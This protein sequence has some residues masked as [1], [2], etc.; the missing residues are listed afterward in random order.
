MMFFKKFVFSALIIAAPSFA[1]ES[2]F[3]AHYQG[4]MR[5]QNGQLP[6]WVQNL[7]GDSRTLC[8]S[9]NDEC[10][11]TCI[12]SFTLLVQ[13]LGAALLGEI[14]AIPVTPGVALPGPS[15]Q[16]TLASA[17]FSN[18]FQPRNLELLQA[19]IDAARFYAEGVRDDLGPIEL[20]AR[21]TSWVDAQRALVT[22]LTSG[23]SCFPFLVF[24]TSALF[25]TLTR[26]LQIFI[27]LRF[28]DEQPGIPLARLNII[29]NLIQNFTLIGAVLGIQACV[30]CDP[31]CDCD[32]DQLGAAG[33]GRGAWWD[34]DQDDDDDCDKDGEGSRKGRGR[35]R[36]RTRGAV[37][38]Y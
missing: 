5:F 13:T 26:N 32:R 37:G 21:Y 24:A 31:I 33:R 28:A 10:T 2:N 23:S 15:T 17:N 34:L 27:A 12:Q 16:R 6:E 7:C 29:E 30:S 38:A 18:F 19:Y 4:G 8:A 1:L 20:L 11:F 25:D 9:L 14:E 22:G 35:H 3:E 36:D